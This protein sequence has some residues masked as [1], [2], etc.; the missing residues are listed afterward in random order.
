MDGKKSLKQMVGELPIGWSDQ[1]TRGPMTL[2]GMREWQ[3]IQA[4]GRVLMALLGEDLGRFGREVLLATVPLLLLLRWRGRLQVQVDFKLPAENAAI[5]AEETCPADAFPVDL[6]D[7]QCMGLTQS[8]LLCISGS[9]VQIMCR[10][11]LPS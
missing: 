11:F 3:D 9:F 10:Y 8:C 5:K 6:T 7:K 4:G 2:I 1:G